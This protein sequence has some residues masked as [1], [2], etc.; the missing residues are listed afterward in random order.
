MQCRQGQDRLDV[1]GDDHGAPAEG[2]GSHAGVIAP[3]Y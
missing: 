2:V 3:V 1:K